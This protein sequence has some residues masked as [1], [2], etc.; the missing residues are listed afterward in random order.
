M[1]EGSA[2]RFLEC[3]CK[4]CSSLLLQN[5]EDAERLADIAQGLGGTRDIF[6]LPPR[7]Q[8]LIQVNL[9]AIGATER[10]SFSESYELSFLQESTLTLET[11]A[12]DIEITRSRLVEVELSASV[13]IERSFSA[14]SLGAGIIA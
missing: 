1:C 4:S 6:S 13:E 11:D 7:N 8:G 14:A 2:N 12:G 9:D 5:R 10:F 3:A